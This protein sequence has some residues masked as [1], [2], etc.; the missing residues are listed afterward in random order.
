VQSGAREVGLVGFEEL[1][2]AEVEELGD[3]SG[4][5]QDVLG[6]DVRGG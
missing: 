4:V 6:L 2:D 3:A 5:L 1:G